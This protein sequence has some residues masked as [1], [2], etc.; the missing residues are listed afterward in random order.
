M[1]SN[2]GH[3]E[4][5]RYTGGAAGDQTGGEWEVRAWYNYPWNCV[6]RHP[7][8]SVRTMIAQMAEAAAANN[9]IGYD[10][11]QRDTFG[12]ELAR[13]GYDP[14]KITAKCETDCSKGVIDI[15]KGVGHR[16]N[17]AALK[18]LNATYTGNMRA[19]FHA[20]GFQVLEEKKYLSGEGSLLRGDILL[21]D[22]CH[23]A[24]CLTDGAVS[25]GQQGGQ[26]APAS[27][28]GTYT[29]K[30]GDSLWGIAQSLLG[31]G[32]R[33]GEIKALNGLTG[34]TIHPGQ[35]LRVPGARTYTVK[36][37]DSLWSIAQSQ[38]GDGSRY[39][40]IKKLNGL[41]GDTIHPGQVLRIPR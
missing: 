34:D 36:A 37:G 39:G 11:G 10:Q 30:A 24:V 13:V 12:R 5:G 3:D 33:Y 20:A 27:G 38:L 16:L 26:A 41:S 8:A 17:I 25:K 15:V 32:S 1:L 2:C 4:N 14:A 18:G 6:L 35:V 31:D 28:T 21:N 40:E 29:V 9:K 23:T 22:S 7:D 19:G